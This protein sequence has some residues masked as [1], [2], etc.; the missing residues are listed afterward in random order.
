MAEGV[1]IGLLVSRARVVSVLKLLLSDLL[2]VVI[3]NN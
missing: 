3:A 2:K 1:N